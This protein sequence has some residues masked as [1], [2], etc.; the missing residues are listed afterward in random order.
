L[1]QARIFY[2]INTIKPTRRLV[3]KQNFH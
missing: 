1:I 2:E 3:W